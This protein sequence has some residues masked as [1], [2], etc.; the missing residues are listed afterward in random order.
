M[1]K[2]FDDGAGADPSES[3]YN[4][5]TISF[6][7]IK[8]ELPL[9]LTRLCDTVQTLEVRGAQLSL[10]VNDLNLTG[11]SLQRRARDGYA[12]WQLRHQLS[13][14]QTWLTPGEK[15]VESYLESMALNQRVLLQTLIDELILLN[16]NLKILWTGLVEASQAAHLLGEPVATLTPKSLSKSELL[17][18]F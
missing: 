1:R 2:Y 17:K 11:L 13:G 9:E 15:N 12:L 16:A 3:L 14:T 10:E 5:Y 6:N 8:G 7:N 18:E 4:I